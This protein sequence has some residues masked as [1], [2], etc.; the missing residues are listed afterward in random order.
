MLP[1]RPMGASLEKVDIQTGDY[2]PTRAATVTGYSLVEAPPELRR[3]GIRGIAC[4]MGLRCDRGRLG[5]SGG[6]EGIDNFLYGYRDAEPTTT[7]VPLSREA[8]ERAKAMCDAYEAEGGPEFSSRPSDLV[9][10]VIARDEE[11][12]EERIIEGEVS[13]T[14]GCDAIRE[15]FDAA[16]E[17]AGTRVASYDSFELRPRDW[18]RVRRQLVR[19]K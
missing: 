1:A 3:R 10:D 5:L 4:R 9:G 6:Y 15:L 14:P 19:G 7:L 8:W 12:G 2:F 13:E 17:E 18:E 16:A 11:Y